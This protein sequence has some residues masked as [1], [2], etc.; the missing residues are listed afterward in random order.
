[1]KH[2]YLLIATLPSSLPPQWTYLKSPQKK[3]RRRLYK[4]L[5]LKLRSHWTESHEIFTRCT[6]MTADY[7]AEIKV[8]IFQSVLERRRDECRTSS[9]CGQIAAKIERLNSKNSEIV[10]RKFTRFGHDVA[11]LLTL[12]T[13]W[14]LIYDQPIRCR[15]PKERV[16]VV[17]CYADCTTS[18]VLNL[19]SLNRI[20]SNFYKMYRND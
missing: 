10:G 19:G 4:F 1:M 5:C 8:V 13:N 20:S 2:L 15:M 17:P 3:N 14:K 6:E 9:N 11:W 12:K 18:Y 7:S 16:K